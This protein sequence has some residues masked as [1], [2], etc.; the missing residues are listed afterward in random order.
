MSRLN[1]IIKNKRIEIEDL[2]R[3]K[4]AG[5]WI[6]ST[7]DRTL[8]KPDKLFLPDR[9]HLIAEIKPKSPTAGTLRESV[10][11][12]EIA[13]IYEQGGASAVSVLTDKKYFGGSFE[14][15][16]RVTRTVDIPVLCKEF[17]LDEI[18][19]EM[20]AQSGADLVLLITEILDDDNLFDLYESAKRLGL[21]P[22]VE[23]HKPENIE[24]AVALGAEIIGINNR[25]L[26]TFEI[27]VTYSSKYIHLIP[28]GRKRF[29]LSGVEKR[30]QAVAIRDC[31][32]DGILVGSFLMSVTDPAETIRELTEL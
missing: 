25:D 1:E 22:F 14:Y 4:E 23:A 9:F 2:Y 6:Y 13:R 3:K 20:A 27:D 16:N 10:D 8:P 17:V 15:L 24:K 19:L 28:N 7:G 11:V 26:F 30:E 21:M 31:G 18:Q 5:E 12:S 29:S 32:F